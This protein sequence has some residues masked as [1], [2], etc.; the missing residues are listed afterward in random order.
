MTVSGSIFLIA[1]GAVL[2]FALNLRVAYLHIDVIG[3]ILIVAGC[4]G[5]ALVLIQ[6]T[7]WA[8]RAREMSVEDRRPPPDLRP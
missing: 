6:Q 7:L 5:L 1:I 3:F 8:R 2:H 4:A